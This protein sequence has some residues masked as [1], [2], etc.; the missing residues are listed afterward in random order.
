MITHL[1]V[2][3]I[4]IQYSQIVSLNLKCQNSSYHFVFIKIFET[5][6]LKSNSEFNLSNSF[7]NLRFVIF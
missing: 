7:N 6:S 5:F 2:S 1:L 3:S 4:T